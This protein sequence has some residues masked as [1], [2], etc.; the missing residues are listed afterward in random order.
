MIQSNERLPA[1]PR[2]AQRYPEIGHSFGWM[3]EQIARIPRVKL[4]ITPTPLIEAHNLT[5]HLGGPRIFV[6]HDE[7]TGIAFGGNKL[8]LLEFRLARSLAEGADTVIFGLDLQSNSARCFAGACNRLR[9]K[10]IL[11]L[12]GKRPAVVQ[13][14]LLVNYLLGAEIHFAKDAAEQRRMLDELAE[15]VRHKGGRPHIL[16]DNPMFY[17]ASALAY[18]E[19]TMEIL[20]QLDAEGLKP[21]SFYMCSGGKGQ[22]GVVLAQR[23]L[24]TGFTMRGVTASQAYEVR[25]RTAEIANETAKVLG[26]D[27]T[28]GPDDVVSFSEFVGEGYGIPT[29]AGVEAVKLFA[30]QE[31]I[32]LDP[33]YTGKGA[34]AM[35]AH[36]REGQFKKDDVVVFIHTGGLP[37]IFTW[38]EL[39]L[40]EAKECCHVV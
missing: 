25:P 10:P 13:G 18:I 19:S 33:I 15:R 9:L 14:N 11:V 6:K 34:A 30:R 37:A 21:H 36:I 32:I 4:A 12:V 22:A 35:I 23:L 24:K 2:P 5:R 8:R 26:L 7:M 38:N 3:R 20:E 27:E 31:G 40:D 28:F 29:P 16:N 1:E 17:A 39:W